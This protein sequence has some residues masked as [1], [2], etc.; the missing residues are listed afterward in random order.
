MRSIATEVDPRIVSGLAGP[1]LCPAPHS[2][3]PPPP[4]GA[5]Q[6][7]PPRP[8]GGPGRVSDGSCSSPTIKLS[9]SVLVEGSAAN[10][11]TGMEQDRLHFKNAEAEEHGS[12]HLN[13]QDT[14]VA[15]WEGGRSVVRHEEDELLLAARLG[16]HPKQQ[17]QQHSGA[18]E[19]ASS[20]NLRHIA[21]P[22]RDVG[23][24]N[25]VRFIGAVRKVSLST[26]PVGCPVY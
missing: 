24:R 13:R 17:Q 19:G 14:A 11:S 4:V 12:A 5:P 7:G 15:I 26:Y 21:A 18:S 6:E 3:V 9:V 2:A 25:A 16:F 10:P 1:F 23:E 8:R 20:A 22:P